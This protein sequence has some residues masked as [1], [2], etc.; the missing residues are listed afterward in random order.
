ME[1]AVKA[2]EVR[3][4]TRLFFTSAGDMEFAMRTTLAGTAALFTAMWLQLDVPRWAMWTV[5]IVSPPVRG[6]ALRKTAARLVGTAIGCNVGI[7]CAALFPQQA[8]GFYI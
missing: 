2:N 3:N 8:V 4:E 7:V 5:F 1:S 6:N